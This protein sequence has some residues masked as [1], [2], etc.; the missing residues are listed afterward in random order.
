MSLLRLAGGAGKFLQA[1]ALEKVK[2]DQAFRVQ[3]AKLQSAADIKAKEDQV[4][5]KVGENSLTFNSIASLGS[6]DE[7][8]ASGVI[9]N[10]TSNMTKDQYTSAMKNGTEQEKIKL[11]NFLLSSHTFW[12]TRNQHKVGKGN[13]PLSA[14]W[15]NVISKYGGLLN[16]GP[17]YAKKVIAPSYGKAIDRFKRYYPKNTVWEQINKVADEDSV[18][19][20][21]APA[22]L[23][24]NGLNFERV[25]KYQKMFGHND[26][27]RTLRMFKLN[28]GS[29]INSDKHV[30]VYD[31]MDKMINEV[32]SIPAG[33]KVEEFNQIPQL[34][35]YRKEAMALGVGNRGW[36]NMLGAITPN[37]T[38]QGTSDIIYATSDDLTKAT[39]SY[40]KNEYNIDVAKERQASEGANK[41]AGTAMT[42]VNTLN[43]VGPLGSPAGFA[44]DRM[45]RQVFSPTGA[46]QSVVRVTGSWFNG[47]QRS[48]D[49]NGKIMNPASTKYVNNFRTT[50]LSNLENKGNDPDDILARRAGRLQYMKFQLAYQMASALQ[51][52]TG[53]RTISDQDVE[54][55]LRAMRFTAGDD[56]EHIIA[57]LS[58]IAELMR[59]TGVIKDYYASGPKGAYAAK[60]LERSIAQYGSLGTYT[61][62]RLE[63][64]TTNKKGGKFA[65]PQSST[66]GKSMIVDSNGQIQFK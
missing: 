40:M 19:L 4:T 13:V 41:A 9:P 33:Q 45:F 8:R 63:E 29:D 28:N 64:I 26:Y 48:L 53:G 22:K 42:M 3:S 24:D 58:G 18:N 43:D 27:K 49:S 5:F 44:V 36:L 50:M 54:N 32:G 52:G 21:W 34:E 17:E 30:Q 35:K 65:I 57:S 25:K 39:A 6:T 51:G 7:G 23:M 61:Y 31:I 47:S 62:A 56:T 14:G 37:L 1:A 59:E 16:Y 60:L 38:L 20:E 46:L 10:I 2:G 12:N 66:T 55:M 15:K 11:N